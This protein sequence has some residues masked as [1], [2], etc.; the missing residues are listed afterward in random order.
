MK[1]IAVGLGVGILFLRLAGGVNAAVVINEISAGSNPEW[2]ELFNT[3]GQAVDL[4][5]WEVS[6]GNSSSSDDIT[7]TVGNGNTVIQ[8]QGF[9]VVERPE[10]WLN[11]SGQET[12]KLYDNA[13]PSANLVD[14]YSFS[15]T[16]ADKTYSRV[17]DGTGG[18]QSGTNPT[19]SAANSAVPTATPTPG[20]TS[21][22]T[23]TPTPTASPTPTKSP[24]PTPTKKPTPTPTGKDE[25]PTPEASGEVT[26]TP[27]E[28]TV[29]PSPSKGEVLG[30]STEKKSRIGGKELIAPA[31]ITGVGVLLL[32]AALGIGIWEKKKAGG[33]M[34]GYGED[35]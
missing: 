5:G 35:D 6:D 19:K 28:A 13:T 26:P 3:G 30:T 4:E 12:V 9:F 7:I 15:G 11:N 27:T 33:K 1:R 23:P 32:L 18:W 8:P 2:V 24:T 34:G 14:S 22:P 31:A 10:G 20:P 25:E 17:P 16:T 29:S 21:T